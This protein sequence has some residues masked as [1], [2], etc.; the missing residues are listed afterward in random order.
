MTSH[1]DLIAA[2]PKAELHLHIEGSFEPEQMMRLA[3]RNKVTLPFKTLEEAKAAYD[4]DNLQAFLDLYYAGMAVLLTEQ[5]FYDLTWAYLQRVSKDNVRHVEMFFDPQAH[6]E[7]GVAFGTV[8]DGILKALKDGEEELGITSKLI[9]SFLRHLSEED[10]FAL[11]EDSAPWHE[12]FIGVGL[13]SS[14]MGHPPLKFERLFQRCR[15]MGFKLCMHAG[16]EGP[17]EYVREALF[18]IGVDRIDHG[19]RS[20]EDRAL[21][22]HLRDTQMTLTNCPLSN[23]SLCVIDKI[24]ESPVKR[25]LDAGLQVTVN[26]DDPAYFGGYMNQNYQAVADALSLSRDEI[27]RLAK[28]S[29]KGSFLSEAETAAHIAAIDETATA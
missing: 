14:E 21:I 26:S 12:H 6:M 27:A 4:F 29:F 24:E 19:N 16:E 10:G 9:M 20:M 17:P 28:N 25:M 11:L 8:A 15:E 23:L 18:D 5:D 13:D 7:R 2:L 3:E 22:D 1:A